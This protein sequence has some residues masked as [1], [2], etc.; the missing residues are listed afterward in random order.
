MPA[1]FRWIAA[2]ATLAA[3]LPVLGARR[4]ASAPSGDPPARAEAAAPVGARDLPETPRRARSEPGAVPPASAAWELT[5]PPVF[6]PLAAA[7]LPSALAAD[8]DRSVF[9]QRLA[10]ADPGLFA[11]AT[12]LEWNLFDDTAHRVVLDHIAWDRA[13]GA[14]VWR[15]RVAG[16]PHSLVIARIGHGIV[17]ASLALSDGTL[18]AVDT[19]APGVQRIQEI[20]PAALPDCGLDAGALLPEPAADSGGGGSPLAAGSPPGSE[21]IDVLLVYTAGA[22]ALFGS[23]AAIE[24]RLALLVD[25]ANAVYA[26]SGSGQR[27]RT[28]GIRQVAYDDSHRSGSTALDHLTFPGDG[29]LDDVHALRDELGADAVTLFTA[30]S[31]VCGIAW[32][33]ASAARIEWYEDYMFNVV[34]ASC[35]GSP[36]TFVH[37]LGHNQGAYHDPVT[38][39]S[40]GMT[41]QQIDSVPPPNSFGYLG[42]GNTFHTVMAYGSSCGGCTSLQQFSNPNL[43]FQGLPTGDQ[44]SNVHGTLEATHAAIAAFRPSQACAGE[45]DT[46]GD[47]VCDPE[48][49]CVN[50]PNPEQFDVNAD[51]FG[52]ACDAD[53][54]DDSMIGVPDFGIF[55]ANFGRSVGSPG[56]EPQADHTGDGTVGVP[57]FQVIFS[58]FGGPPGPSGLACAGSAPCP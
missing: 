39:R 8:P 42:P 2:F 50:A 55:A 43:S 48:D 49:N 58:G 45:A 4:D 34:S 31:N 41:Q 22:R 6:Q 17:T 30:P 32:V 24:S 11:G 44:R 9:R 47:G 18:F 40:Q 20:D 56:T 36:R 38:S 51:G 28:A 25:W 1:R 37:E 19:L 16:D 13:A 33:A 26:N 14:T 54:T 10:R 53:Y 21:P 52:N 3:V 46:D 29:K 23:T 12:Q 27:L 7:D 5:P 15:G 35:T 57:D